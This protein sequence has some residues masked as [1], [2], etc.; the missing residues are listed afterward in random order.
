MTT[1]K[2]RL[3][4]EQSMFCSYCPVLHHSLLISHFTVFILV[5]YFISELLSF[6]MQC[7]AQTHFGR[8]RR[9]VYI[10][11]TKGVC[12]QRFMSQEA[13]Y[14]ELILQEQEG[15]CLEKDW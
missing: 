2:S 9:H 15:L 3:S 12:A 13:S 6:I 1:S 7:S 4:Q 8:Q 11:K 14:H 10:I 5:L